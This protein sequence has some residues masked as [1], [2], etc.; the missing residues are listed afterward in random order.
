M[1]ATG[2]H[3]G[4]EE[5]AGRHG[6][7]VAERRADLVSTRSP[8]EGTPHARTIGSQGA[9]T[10]YRTG[11]IV[12]G[13]RRVGPRSVHHRIRNWRARD[14]GPVLRLVGST[15]LRNLILIAVVM[16]LVFVLLP[17]ALGAQWASAG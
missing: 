14:L 11:V 3:G 4:G 10:Q 8:G 6:A 13:A 2:P 16:L 1:A 15:T 7:A 9:S 17:A 12:R 5:A